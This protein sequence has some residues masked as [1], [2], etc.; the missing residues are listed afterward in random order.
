MQVPIF[1]Q[2]VARGVYRAKA[3]D[4]VAEGTTRD[5][6]LEHLSVLL[7]AGEVVT[8]EMRPKR[9]KDWRRVAG[10]F[11]NDAT[12]D[13]LQSNIEQRRREENESLGI[14]PEKNR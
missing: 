4:M 11:E 6:A 10:L 13:E 9:S 2:Q 3:W 12:F 8:L 14:F 7:E 5:E 1:V